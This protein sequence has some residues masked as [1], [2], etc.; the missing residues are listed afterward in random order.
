MPHLCPNSFTLAMGSVMLEEDLF[1]IQE[2]RE[3]L[4]KAKEAQKKLAT[5]SQKQLDTII[6]AMA[7]AGLQASEKLARLASGETGMGRVESKIAKNRF[8]VQDIYEDIRP[9]K[10]VG[11]LP[12]DPEK[13]YYEVAEGVGV[14]AA[15][16]PTTN[17]TSTTIF[18]ALIALK[19]G[20]CIVFAP[21]PR[22]KR[23]I[24]ESAKI[25]YEAALMAGAP[26][27]CI[28][29]VTN[30]TLES[31]QT[32]MSHPDTAVIL[33]TGGPGLV[34]AAY[35]SGK[36]AFGVGAG[37]PPV[38]IERSADITHAVRCIVESQTFDYGTLCSSEQSVVVD[39][40]I[41][42]QVK[43]QFLERG[44][45]FLN[46]QESKL[47]SQIAVKN[48]MMTAEVVGQPA[49]R[50]AQMAGINV[51][52]E[53]TVLLAPLEGTGPEFPLSYEV[54]A[55]ILGFYVVQNWSEA[56]QLSLDLLNLGGRGH[57]LGIHSTN[58]DIL[59]EFAIQVPVS[60]VIVNAPTSQGSVGFA[61]H[62]DPSMTLGCGTFG[63][64]ITSDNITARHLLNIK[65][66]SAIDKNFPLWENRPIEQSNTEITIS[67]LCDKSSSPISPSLG[68]SQSK[69]ICQEKSTKFKTGRA[70][71]IQPLTAPSL[72]K[73]QKSGWPYNVV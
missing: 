56:C 51:P 54:L 69:N 48:N 64:N 3:L 46:S 49:Y 50:I 2:V 26:E 17:P 12:F 6:D 15:V 57:T 10:T 38:V 28:G 52:Q 32:L 4:A 68:L 65:Q 63:R 39:A 59:M 11:A 44:G 24:R 70:K 72:P 22:A 66:I 14:V 47:V 35:C 67:D 29:C 40:P 53:T 1:A 18:K 37:N 60:R 19:S 21:H 25:V 30:P 61:T 5:Y 58:P 73:T 13:G 71:N 16:I 8:A 20:N 33:A 36:P 41:L 9:L 31:T 62:L 23:C 27:G 43:A 55:P 42:D 7:Q 34:R 45:Y